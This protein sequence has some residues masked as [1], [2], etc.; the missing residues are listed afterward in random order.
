VERQRRNTINDVRRL[1]R[2][3]SMDEEMNELEIIA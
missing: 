1:Q 2:Q 3:N